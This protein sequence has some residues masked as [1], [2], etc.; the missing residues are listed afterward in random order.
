MTSL[1]FR[2][3]AATLLSAGLLLGSCNYSGAPENAQNSPQNVD[4]TAIRFGAPLFH[5][6]YHAVSELSVAKMDPNTGDHWAVRLQKDHE[7]RWLISG[8]PDG[9]VLSDHLAN[10]NFVDHLLDTLRT[11]TLLSLAPNASAETIGLSPPRFSIRWTAEGKQHE[12][13]IGDGAYSRVPTLSDRTYVGQGALFGMLD[14][15]KA[16]SVLRLPTL[17]DFAADDMD[18]IEMGPGTSARWYAQ[19]EGGRWTDRKH[20]R[21]GSTGAITMEDRLSGV[22]HT[23]IRDYLDDAD[24]AR[25]WAGRI[26]HSP[27]ATVT[28]KDRAGK[29]TVIRVVRAEFQGQRELMGTIS[30]RPGAVF[31]LYPEALRFFE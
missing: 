12:I 25:D 23:R 27:F 16:F 14:Y 11:F 7:G 9:R 4:D 31:V 6:D 20:R 8:A 17:C 2:N 28:L 29:A 22:V 13:Q 26:E 30:S 10:S 1:N 24:V 3:G 18:E 5:F 15:L 21:L 19:R